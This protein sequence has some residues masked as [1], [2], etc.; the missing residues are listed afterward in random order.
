V[1]ELEG[2][3]DYAEIL[4][5]AGVSVPVYDAVGES[6][7]DSDV[8]D[9]VADDSDTVNAGGKTSHRAQYLYRALLLEMSTLIQRHTETYRSSHQHPSATIS[10]STQRQ[11]QTATYRRRQRHTATHRRMHRHSNRHSAR[12]GYPQPH[13]PPNP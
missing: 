13:S 9:S 11:R 4:R 5:D 2:D 6:V 1:G 3:A 7:A 8:A 10:N 12:Q